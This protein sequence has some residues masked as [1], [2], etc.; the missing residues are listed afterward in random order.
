[1]G[2]GGWGMEDGRDGAR[3][4]DVERERERPEKAEGKSLRAANGTNRPSARDKT[5]RSG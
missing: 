1:M 2:D 3:E 4:R 5:Q